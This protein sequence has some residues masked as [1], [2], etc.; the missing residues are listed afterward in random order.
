MKRSIQGGGGLLTHTHQA[1]WQTV[2]EKKKSNKISKFSKKGPYFQPT[3]PKNKQNKRPRGG[4]GGE[5]R[6]KKEGD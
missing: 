4:G 5:S 2:I 1:T 6:G 3:G